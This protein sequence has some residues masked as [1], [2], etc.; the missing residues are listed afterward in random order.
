MK[1]KQFLIA[2]T[3]FSLLATVASLNQPTLAADSNGK[4]IFSDYSEFRQACNQARQ[5][6]ISKKLQSNVPAEIDAKNILNLL[7]NAGKEAAK[8][9]DPTSFSK[10]LAQHGVL[11]YD[12]NI[13]SLSGVH[14]LST[15]SSV[16]VG[17]P[18]IEYFPSSGRYAVTGSFRWTDLYY[19][20]ADNAF[21]KGNVGGP[22]TMV[23]SFS[24]I[25]HPENILSWGAFAWNYSGDQTFVSYNPSSQPRNATALAVEFRGQDQIAESTT[26][27][28]DYTWFD[29]DINIVFNQGFG[30]ENGNVN[31]V[32]GHTWNST[33]VTGI[34]L[35]STGGIT[36]HFSSSDSSWQAA[37]LFTGY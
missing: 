19:P 26:N 5:D 20:E 7:Q 29:G 30:S 36:V 22:D 14:P 27:I 23:L 35:S 33:S 8:T 10:Y 28:Q 11:V 15:N 13:S 9:H 1:M 2:G 18:Y 6:I 32:Y 34:D 17:R 31:F 24:S 12:P 4:M 3:F 37:G 21:Q 25:T 16:V